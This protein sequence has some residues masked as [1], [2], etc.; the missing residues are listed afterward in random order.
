M[1]AK[2]QDTLHWILV[3]IL[4]VMSVTPTIVGLVSQH[5]S[6]QDL[7]VAISGTLVAVATKFVYYAD[8]TVG[9]TPPTPS[10]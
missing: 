9:T 6:G 4:W 2:L 1:N 7:V 3:I 8:N 5:L 10:V